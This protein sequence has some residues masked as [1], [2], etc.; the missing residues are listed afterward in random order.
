MVKLLGRSIGY[1]FLCKKVE[2]IWKP[3]GEIDVI[4]LGY[5]FFL[6]KFTLD[7][8]IDTVLNESPWVIQDHYL[9]VR[10]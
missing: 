6:V 1:Q 4:D 7:E 9:T 3:K 2:Q 5:S 10:R 8:D